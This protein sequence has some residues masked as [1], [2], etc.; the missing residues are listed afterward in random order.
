[1][2][3]ARLGLG[4][5]REL[6]LVPALLCSPKLPTRRMA[7]TFYRS[8][9]IPGTGGHPVSLDAAVSEGRALGRPVVATPEPAAV[10]EG[11]ADPTRARG[12]EQRR[13]DPRRGG[14]LRC[15]LVGRA[16]RP[17]VSSCAGQGN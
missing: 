1:M 3:T 6:V 13:A 16:G 7:L 12:P 9:V 8:V 2:T 11:G 17:P 15:P 10:P 5:T 4:R 14:S